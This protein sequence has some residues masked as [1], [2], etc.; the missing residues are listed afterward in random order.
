MGGG[1]WEESRMG[2]EGVGG[3]AG[4]KELMRTRRGRGQLQPGSNSGVCCGMP[5]S[6]TRRMACTPEGNTVSQLLLLCC[7][8]FFFLCER[9]LDDVSFVCV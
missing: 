5:E 6:T 3:R 2:S 1:K 9:C 8:I 7:V 4:V